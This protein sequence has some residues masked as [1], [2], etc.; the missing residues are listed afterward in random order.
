MVLASTFIVTF[1]YYFC[2][3]CKNNKIIIN[4]KSNNYYRK[5]I[6]SKMLNYIYTKVCT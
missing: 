5:E 2:H 4:Q 6:I 1:G 3:L